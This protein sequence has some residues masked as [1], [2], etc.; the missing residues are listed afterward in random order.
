MA[1]SPQTLEITNFSGRLTRIPN[2]DLNS[3][4][5]KFTASYGYDPFSKP[6]N[7]TWMESPTNISGVSDL[8]MDGKVR[9]IGENNPVVYLIGSTGNLYKV[10]INSSTNNSVHS[11]IAVSSVRA[12]SPT[13][14]KGAS[15]EFFGANEKIYV[16]NDKQVNS[17][18][19]DGSA[20]AVVGSAG[21]YA[22]NVFR[23]LQRFIGNLVFGNGNTVG[24]I[25][26]SGTV[27]SSVIGVSSTIGNVYS[28]LNPPL[29]S[30]TR[31][32][33]LD[34]SPSNDYL[35]IA[36]A[37]IDYEN[38]STVNTPNRLNTVPADSRI[39]YWNGTDSTVTAANSLST[40]LIASLQTYLGRNHFF[41]SDSFGAGVNS[42]TQKL[43]TM[44]DN[45]APFPNATGVNGNFLH[46][47]APEKVVD[48]SGTTRLFTALYYFGSLDGENPPGLW[49]IL[50]EQASFFGNTIQVPFNLLVSTKY[51]DVNT[52]QSSVVAA[53]VGT[54]YY[55]THE[56]SRDNE[57]GSVLGLNRI[58]IPPSS[59]SAKSG[60]TYETQT[61]LFSKRIGVSQIR[62]YTEP[63]VAG[64]AF[65]LDLIGSDGAVI[66]NGTFTYTFGD[67]VDRSVRINF[68]PSIQTVYA[69]GVR[70]TNTGATNMTIKKIELDI[71]EEGK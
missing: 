6:F 38:I 57:F 58:N 56:I 17:I 42:D 68:N 2:G 37:D 64:N 32:K 48:S 13:Y 27:L 39:N 41:S 11:V 61:Q 67:P 60:A 34:T 24:M 52:T 43:L 20:D 25:G 63:V 71:T 45:K 46:W 26:A 4:F 44:Q 54:H 8:V 28:S 22:A 35:I 19:F 7:L 69:L 33:D 49:R 47:A 10:Q 23:P 5:A 40:S 59:T 29:P 51:F 55:S 16:G 21:S 31:V 70:I 62:V 36:S 66:P 50:R 1:K 30:S 18:N 65:Q 3:G 53:G 12:G 15:L 9:F 14:V